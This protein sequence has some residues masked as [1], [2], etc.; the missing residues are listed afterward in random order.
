M[1]RVSQSLVTNLIISENCTK[2]SNGTCQRWCTIKLKNGKHV[3]AA[4]KA[5]TIYDLLIGTPDI[6]SSVRLIDIARWGT[7]SADEAEVITPDKLKDKAVKRQH[8][9]TAI[10]R[11]FYITYI[12]KTLGEIFGCTMLNEQA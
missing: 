5:A 6:D 10:S 7:Y 8:F 12:Q 4:L 11:G 1:F 9:D 3:T 2:L